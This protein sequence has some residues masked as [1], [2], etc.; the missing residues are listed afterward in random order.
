[1]HLGRL[2]RSRP[3]GVLGYHKDIGLER[4]G[5][6]TD[7]IT[8]LQFTFRLEITNNGETE[9]KLCLDTF[10]RLNP[11]CVAPRYQVYFVSHKLLLVS[12]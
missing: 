6:T 8:A 9:T 12:C 3:D 1:M 5:H 4:G 7:I 11:V 2:E 10:V